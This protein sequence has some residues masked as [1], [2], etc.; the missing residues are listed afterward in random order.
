LLDFD[1]VP[2]S[3]REAFRRE[4]TASM[5]GGLY[6]GMIMPF[7]M[8][9]AR[10]NLKASAIIIGFMAAAPFLGS[11][12]SIFWA[13]AM[14]A[15]PKMPFVVWPTAI[16]RAAFLLLLFCKTPLSFALIIFVSQFLGSLTGPA[17]AAIIKA[18]YPEESRGRIMSYVRV[19][20]MFVMIIATFIAGALLKVISYRYI[21]PAAGAIGI[22]AIIQ[23]GRIRVDEPFAA[24]LPP[25]RSEFFKSTLAILAEDRS[26]RWF[27]MSVF[28]YG[29]ANLILTP[30]YPIFQVDRLH[31]T[32]VQAAILVNIA[33]IVWMAGVLYWGHYVD[34]KSP[35]SAVAVCVFLSGIIPITYLFAQNVW[36]LI[37]AFIVS[38]WISSGIELSYF[39][40]VLKLAPEHRVSQYQALF[41]SLLGVRGAVAPFIGSWL[42][43]VFTAVGWDYKYL[44]LISL[45]GMFVGGS[46]QVYGVRGHYKRDGM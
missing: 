17:Y 37:P 14:E 13:H 29:F 28:V 42:M 33:S 19:G 36:M 40:S 6:A 12:F 35:L 34:A 2:K 3:A 43:T 15:R 10:D 1:S 24:S 16:G 30:I 32:T 23:F 21:F 27:A 18:V 8:I 7:Y 22:V 38:G 20:M 46:M 26:F 11:L 5:L 41:Q 44:F 31:I 25:R 4:R 45:V 39:N 9:I